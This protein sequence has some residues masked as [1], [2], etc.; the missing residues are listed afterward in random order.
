M[1]S[2]EVQQE[3]ALRRNYESRWQ[4]SGEEHVEDSI[5]NVRI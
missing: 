2:D 1:E 4:G 3:D 5:A